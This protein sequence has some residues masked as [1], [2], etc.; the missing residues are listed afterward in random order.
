LSKRLDE[1]KKRP[2]IAN[3]NAVKTLTKI[4]AEREQTY[5]NTADFIVKTDNKTPNQITTEILKNIKI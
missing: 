4:L 2:L 5:L 1:S 3:K